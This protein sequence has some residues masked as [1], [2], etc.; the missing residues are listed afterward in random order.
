MSDA[1]DRLRNRRRQSVPPRDAS[2]TPTGT[3]SPQT[4][5]SLDTSMSRNLEEKTPE[6]LELAAEKRPDSQTSGLADTDKSRYLEAVDS[7]RLDQ[8]VP[9]PTPLE[10]KQSTMRLERGLSDRLQ[11]LSRKTGVCREAL[12]E[13]MFEHME[14]NPSAQGQVLSNAQTKNEHRQQ[15]A[16]HK[17]ARSMMKRFGSKD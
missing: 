10:T 16:N 11:A 5:E 3:N 13:A 9:E 8:D 1:L 6:N 7:S 17:R 14:A 2:L 12:I 4:S 15:L